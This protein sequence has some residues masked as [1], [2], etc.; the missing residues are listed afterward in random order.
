VIE[1]NTKNE[2][3]QLQFIFYFINYNFK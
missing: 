2:L 3:T 1:Q